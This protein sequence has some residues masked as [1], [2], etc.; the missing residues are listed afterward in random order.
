MKRLFALLFALLIIAL[1][2][3]IQPQSICGDKVCE[4]SETALNCQQDCSSPQAMPSKTPPITVQSLENASITCTDA[5]CKGWEFPLSY[6]ASNVLYNN[7]WPDSDGPISAIYANARYQ[8]FIPNV[9]SKRCVFEAFTSLSNGRITE[10]KNPKCYPV[11]EP[12]HYW[13][14]QKYS[15]IYGIAEISANNFIASVHGETYNFSPYPNYE[16][17]EPNSIGYPITACPSNDKR[18]DTWASYFGTPSLLKFSASDLSNS[19]YML[20]QE[21]HQLGPPSNPSSKLYSGTQFLKHGLRH[22][23]LL[24][25]SDKKSLFVYTLEQT[26][27]LAPEYQSDSL[28]NFK[29]QAVKLSLNNAQITKA[30]KY[31]NGAWT[32]IAGNSLFKNYTGQQWANSITPASNI[33]GIQNCRILNDL[34]ASP[35]QYLTSTFS[36]AFV[37]DLNVYLGLG[38]DEGKA[39][40]ESPYSIITFRLSRDAVNWTCPKQIGLLKNNEN[41]NPAYA[42][43]ISLDLKSTQRIQSTGFYIFYIDQNLAS[44]KPDIYY[45]KASLSL[46]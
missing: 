5:G 38:F 14:S 43:I 33:L 34:T 6:T 3:C 22:P 35:E 25:S 32:Q 29:R 27:Y 46:D 11:L 44:D 39:N 15:G 16:G 23:T 24:L 31:N 45:A 40:D 36:A 10:L 19:T 26:Y 13:W 4:G 42:S 37:E 2:G 9:E 8:F 30:E 7:Y 41:F 1:S 18:Q 21:K 20:N 28:N 12:G 17:C